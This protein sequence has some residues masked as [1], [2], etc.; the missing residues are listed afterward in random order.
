MLKRLLSLVL[1]ISVMC[2]VSIFILP[3]S[4]VSAAPAPQPQ[5]AIP[6]VNSLPN[7]PVNYS[8]IDWNQRARDFDSFVFNAS[9]TG[10]YL[11]LLQWDTTHHNMST[12]SFKLPAYVG[13][14]YALL[15]GDQEAVVGL[16]SVLGASLAGIDKSN[17][18][19]GG[20]SNVNF[21]DMTRNFYTSEGIIFNKPHNSVGFTSREQEFWYTLNVTVQFA[22]LVDLYPSTSMDTIFQNVADKWYDALV[23]MGGSNLNFFHATYDFTNHE[24]IDTIA[25]ELRPEP[26]SAMAAGLLMYMAYKKFGTQKYLD[27]AKWCQTFIQ[28]LTKNPSYE[29]LQFI[30]PTLAAR[31]NAELNQHNNVEKLINWAFDTDTTY[32][33][34]WGGLKGTYGGYGMDG[35]VG[36]SN[37]NGGNY[38]FAMNTFSAAKDL[39]PTARYDQR[40]AKAIGKWMLNLASNSRLFYADQLDANHQESTGWAL[41][42]NHA[43]PYEGLRYKNLNNSSIMPYA[44]GD[45]INY[46]W[47]FY[48]DLG[49]YSGALSGVLGG[50]VSTTNVSKILKLDLLKTDFFHDTAYPSYLYYNPY[51]TSQSVQINL[52][53]TAYDIYDAVTDTILSQN[54]T[55]TQTFSIPADTARVIVL[56]PANSSRT[57]SG[58]NVLL[59]NVFVSHLETSAPVGSTIW[60][61]ANSNGKFAS[62]VDGTNTP[63]NAVATSPDTWEQYLVVDSGGGTIALKS[64]KNNKYL[65]ATNDT[66]HSLLASATGIGS[67]EK[68]IWQDSGSGNI[69]LFSPQW[70]TYVSVDPGASGAPLKASSTNSTP[71]T[72]ELFT[73]GKFPPVGKTIWLKANSNLKYAS[74]VDGT[75]TPIKA[76]ATSPSTWEQFLVVDGGGGTI[77]LK[78]I[79]NNNYLS[80]SDDTGHTLYAS[81]TSIGSWEKFIW[82]DTRNGKFAALYSPQWNTYV[83]VDPGASGAPLK[84]SS[85]NSTPNSWE[86]FIWDSIS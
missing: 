83:S 84:A 56:A 68:F 11:P 57:V 52:G 85:T 41:D 50:I 72:W 48:T 75:N 2:S 69:A 51:T 1:V 71:N 77:A 79:R 38:A 63:I 24:I 43:I 86:Y 25:G 9:A 6:Y 66:G 42:T 14:K 29:V 26:D 53:S 40:F 18:S 5:I 17:Q 67:W 62:A 61:K 46:N 37:D 4:H 49:L 35:L 28:N 70:N 22:Q 45:P 16:S 39:V 33:P 59:N 27:A 55:G 7:Q 65:S 34:Y 3:L 13:M 54:V 78:S 32:R 58:N 30:G 74:A 76:V 64:L 47:E 36:S 23:D 15:D 12:N 19:G 8:M 21:V 44:T 10:Q 73:W 82:Q 81:A 31:M 80:A 60:L 20:Y